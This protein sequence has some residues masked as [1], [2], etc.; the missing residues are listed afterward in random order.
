MRDVL[1]DARRAELAPDAALLEPAERREEV[2]AGAGDAERPRTHASRD[3]EP[4]GGIGGP[5][6]TGQAVVRFVGDANGVVHAAVGE[7]TMIK[8]NTSRSKRPDSPHC[9]G[10]A[11]FAP[12]PR[13]RGLTVPSKNGMLVDIVV[14]QRSIGGLGVGPVLAGRRDRATD[15]AAEWHDWLAPPA[16]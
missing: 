10:T 2:G 12:L 16:D 3:V 1:A 13:T 11:S 7:L 6:T 5:D 15:A 8:A 9:C 14:G 4:C